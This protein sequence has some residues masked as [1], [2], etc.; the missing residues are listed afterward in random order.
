MITE[1]IKVERVSEQDINEIVILHCKVFEN[2][3]LKNL[4]IDLVNKY[5]QAYYCDKGTIFFKASYKNEIIGFI[6]VT[7]NYSNIIKSFY[8]DNFFSLSQKIVIETLK[9]NRTIF[10]GLKSRIVNVFKTSKEA[11]VE[12]EE[13]CLLSIAIV[14]SFRGKKIADLLIGKVEMQLNHEHVKAYSLSV[15]KD[16]I[17]AK[18]FYKKIGFEKIGGKGELEY[19]T[20][21]L[22]FREDE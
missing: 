15:K 3:F 10:S 8:K 19:Y 17:R 11:N 14:D 13:N 21:K 16:N 9:M 2:Y 4:G 18:N 20:K 6:L 22:N 12:E 5:Y 1:E 7:S